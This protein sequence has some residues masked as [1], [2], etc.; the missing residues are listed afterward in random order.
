MI[1]S[2]Q[3]DVE[4]QCSQCGDYWDAQLIRTGSAGEPEYGRHDG[5]QSPDFPTE[6]SEDMT[7]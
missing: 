1:V 7:P 2:A 6:R 5:A 3:G 4:L